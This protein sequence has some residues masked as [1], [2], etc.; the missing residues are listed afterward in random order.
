MGTPG[1]QPSRPTS[2]EHRWCGVHRAVVVDAVDP[3]SR[4]RV[5]VRIPSLGERAWAPLALA[6]R[7][8]SA[9][10]VP[11]MDDVVLV[12]FEAGDASRPFVIGTLWSDRPR[13][14]GDATGGAADDRARPATVESGGDGVEASERVTFETSGGRQVVLDDT[15]GSI[16][17]RDGRGN[18]ITLGLD[19][20]A[21]EAAATVTI[22]AATI[23][24]STD[25]LAVDAGASRFS[26]LVQSTAVVTNSVVSASYSPGAG[27]VM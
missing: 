23:E 19:G 7:D 5:Q 8:G 16:T 12:A 20:V 2:D 18:S 13:P 1:E 17:I 4:G 26:G 14:P 25:L 3:A 27:N 11:E 15:T 9:W 24:L 21:I 22:R 10:F 6:G